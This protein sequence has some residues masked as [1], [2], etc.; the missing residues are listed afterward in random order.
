M[1]HI[2]ETIQGGG[3]ATLDPA[4]GY[5]SASNQLLFD[6]YDTMLL[7]VGEQSGGGV[8]E[9]AGIVQYIPSLATTAGSVHLLQAHLPTRTS[10]S[11]IW[12]EQAS[13]SIKRALVWITV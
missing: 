5:D 4:G 12:S 7:W 11:T 6:N 1:T 2:E 3:P 10:P 8:E 9:A 13:T